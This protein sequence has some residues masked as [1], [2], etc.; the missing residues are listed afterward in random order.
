MRIAKSEGH[1]A[2]A[3]HILLPPGQWRLGGMNFVGREAIEIIIASVERADMIK[4]QILPTADIARHPIG[5]RRPEFAT[6]GTA[7]PA[8][9]LRLGGFHPPVPPAVAWLALA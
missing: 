4:A 1:A 2:T 3:H 9:G 6:A 5:P 8:T 7:R